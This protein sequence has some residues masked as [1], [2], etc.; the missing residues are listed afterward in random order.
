MKNLLFIILCFITLSSTAQKTTTTYKI[1]GQ[2]YKVY[3]ETLKDQYKV[4]RYVNEKNKFYNTRP[5]Y[6][7]DYMEQYVDQNLIKINEQK[8]LSIAREI[9]NS[10]LKADKTQTII[11]NFYL[12]P[13]TGGVLEIS[14]SNYYKS[15]P[16]PENVY[17]ELEKRLLNEVK[18]EIKT[19]RYQKYPFVIRTVLLTYED[20]A[21]QE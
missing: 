16:I 19:D 14:F 9:I 11:I 18:A 10:T 17:I 2:T 1:Q 7:A 15:E 21:R 3:S 12:N 13:V 8:V 4:N 20:L 5:G 6:A